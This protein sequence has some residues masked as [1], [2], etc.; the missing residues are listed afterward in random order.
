[1]TTMRVRITKCEGSLVW[2]VRESVGSIALTSV[3]TGFLKY[4]KPVRLEASKYPLWDHTWDSR[5]V[6]LYFISGFSA[7]LQQLLS[8]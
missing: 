6:S 3:W 1:M 2:R 8:S 4:Q 7:K 5:E